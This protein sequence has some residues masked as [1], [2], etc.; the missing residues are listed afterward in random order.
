[1]KKGPTDRMY[2]RAYWILSALP[3]A[4]GERFERETF[5]S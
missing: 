4:F 1:M 2:T 5:S 3:T